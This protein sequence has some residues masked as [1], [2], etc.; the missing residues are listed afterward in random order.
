MQTFT[1][2]QIRELARK[3]V[4]FRSH[5]IVYLVTNGALW[6]IWWF[7]GHG[8][9]WPIW[10]MIGWGIGVLFH[11]LFDYRTSRIL[12]EET[13][14]RRLKKEMEEQGMVP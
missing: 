5:L 14:Y 1:D 11:Y 8:Y 4:E 2:T 3:R 7:T 9:M 6:T 12:S 13:E 10:P